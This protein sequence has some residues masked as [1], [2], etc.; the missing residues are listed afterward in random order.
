MIGFT[1]GRYISEKV[2]LDRLDLF[3]NMGCDA[4]ELHL[5][6]QDLDYFN[7]PP[8][9]YQKLKVFKYVALHTPALNV[10]FD[11]SD[12]SRKMMDTVD[13]FLEKSQAQSVVIHPDRISIPEIL[14]QRN[15]PLTLENMDWRK[16]DAK[17]IEQMD[18]WFEIFPQAKMVLDWN[19]I[20]TNDQSMKLG[21]LMLKKFGSKITHYHLSG[22]ID[23]D[24]LHEP[25]LTSN[26]FEIAK[27]VPKDGKPII[28]EVDTTNLDKIILKKEIEFLRKELAR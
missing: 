28:I 2:F 21:K 14:A 20:F 15:W 25:I 23:E 16:N 10:N 19:H 17:S 13:I 8:S 4:I 6:Q 11:A 1:S 26:S 3:V 18:K 24:R 7:Y 22:F 9:I 5:K 12:I 27:S